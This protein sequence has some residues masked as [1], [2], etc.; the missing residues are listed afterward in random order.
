MN[1]SV[2]VSSDGKKVVTGSHDK[3]AILWDMAKRRDRN[4]LAD[5]ERLR[6]FQPIP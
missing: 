4:T 1:T 5:G 2:A 3:T 6:T